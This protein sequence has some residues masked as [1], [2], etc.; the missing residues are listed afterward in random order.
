VCAVFFSLPP[1]PCPFHDLSLRSLSPW[2]KGSPSDFGSRNDS[3]WLELSQRASPAFIISHA[4]AVEKTAITRPFRTSSILLLLL[5]AFLGVPL[6]NLR[7]QLIGCDCGTF[8]LKEPLKFRILF[9]QHA[10][11]LPQIGKLA[12]LRSVELLQ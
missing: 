4:R 2:C 5:I 12:V 3:I 8:Q 7:L 9:S 10:N 6:L 11:L 1:I